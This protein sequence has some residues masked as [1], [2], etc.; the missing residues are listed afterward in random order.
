MDD[1][2]N[3]AREQL[4]STKDE[5]F[6]NG[7]HLQSLPMRDPEYGRCLDR[8]G[9]I[10]ARIE[11]EERIIRELEEAASR[12]MLER[13]GLIPGNRG[14]SGNTSSNEFSTQER[15]GSASASYGGLLQHNSRRD[16]DHG[17]GSGHGSNIGHGSSIG[18]GR[19]TGMG[20]GYEGGGAG[21]DLAST[22]DP[23]ALAQELRQARI[24]GSGAG[25]DGSWG[26]DADAGSRR[27]MPLTTGLS[28]ARTSTG[29]EA[30]AVHQGRPGTRKW[31]RDVSPI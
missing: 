9:A 2:L 22:G 3:A 25:N 15:F 21:I 18:R 13:E 1:R 8:K 20:A 19:Q 7:L 4:R 12:R 11:D 24:T 30:S 16:E 23:P 17:S 29:M 27:F 28:T 5:L 26:S 31:P 10:E 6:A 14:A